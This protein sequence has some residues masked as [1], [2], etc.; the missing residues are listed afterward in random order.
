MI[1]SVITALMAAL[2]CATAYASPGPDEILDDPALEARATEL[3]GL[4]R[5]VVCQSQSLQNSNATLAE[6]MRIVVRERLLAGDSNDAILAYMQSRYG[7]YVL[8]LPP[9]QGNTLAL[10]LFPFVILI[11]GGVIA[12]GYIRRQSG[13]AALPLDP[14]EEARLAKLMDEEGQE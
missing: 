1:R 7:D 13:G 14:E 5:C 11:A 6:D 4:L 10:W 9:V 3:Y 12:F 2:H 8:L